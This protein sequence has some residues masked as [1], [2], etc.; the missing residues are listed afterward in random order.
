MQY[1]DYRVGFTFE[2][3]DE[4]SEV[5]EASYEVFEVAPNTLHYFIEL[6]D[7][8]E[9]VRSFSLSN[10]R[11]VKDEKDCE[12]L[13]D[14]S[15]ALLESNGFKVEDREKLTT[16][17]DRIIYRYVLRDDENDGN[18]LM[19]IYFTRIKDQV[20]ISSRFINEGYDENELEMLQIFDSFE[21]L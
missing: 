6:D 1:R 12:R 2:V 8:G 15:V 4:F 11:K 5:K 7:D 14:D 18:P 10:D 9:I 20:V 3:P 19:V 17:K 21:E 16:N 13:A